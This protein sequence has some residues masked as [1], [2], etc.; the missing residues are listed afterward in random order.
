MLFG[1]AATTAVLLQQIATPTQRESARLQRDARNA[2]TRFESVRRMNLPRRPSGGTSLCD[3]RIG[4]YCYTYDSLEVPR[5]DES[6]SIQ[7]ARERLLGVLD[8]AA[9]SNPADEWIAGQRVRYLLEANRIDDAV[10]ASH[11]CSGVRWWCAALEGLSLHVGQRYA[12]ADS[13]FRLALDVM[14]ATQ[15]C[16]WMDLRSV[17]STALAREFARADCNAKTG[18][19]NELW[20]LSRPL[21]STPG[22]DLRT[23]HL[24]RQ[25]MAL[26]LDHSA[27]AHGMPFGDDSR[28]LLVRYGWAEWYTRYESGYATYGSAV[29]TGHDR[30]PSYYFYPEVGSRR[31]IASVTD[32][33]WT[34]RL[35]TA[36]SRYAPRHLTALV[37]LPHQLVRLPAEGDS[38]RIA[39]AYAVHDTALEHD[40]LSSILAVMRGERLALSSGAR[41]TATLSAT[42]PAESSVVSIEVTGA[43]SKRAARARYALAPIARTARAVLSDIL[44]FDPRGVGE[45]AERDELLTHALTSPRVRTSQPLGV[46]WEARVAGE[47]VPV[48]VTLAVVPERIGLV[49]R[50]AARLKVAAEPAPVRLRWQSTAGRLRSGERV[51]LN[52]PANARG[53]YRVTL[54]VEGLSTSRLVEI[55]GN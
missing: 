55:T 39:V 10:S 14:P 36:P 42:L 31:A 22:N 19:A 54:S 5:P 38:M 43:K 11:A 32:A 45:V 27:N 8:S 4:R 3:A 53:R 34:P 40:S 51:V 23:E 21:W 16:E 41:T 20:S 25:T 24:A 48:W 18:L 28:E 12:A 46:Y 26:I 30:E 9:A 33:S 37:P 47:D 50:I 13:V 17:L 7:S 2:Q 6:K 49:R 35:R 29:I 15:R 44:L 52:L 1:L